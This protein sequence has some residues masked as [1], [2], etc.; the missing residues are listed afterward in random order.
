[1]TVLYAIPEQGV[2]WCG[3]NGVTPVSREMSKKNVTGKFDLVMV[4]I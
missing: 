3:W 1:M 4:I 2:K